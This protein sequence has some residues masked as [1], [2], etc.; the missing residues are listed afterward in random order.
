M[1]LS[2]IQQLWEKQDKKLDK[3]LKLKTDL[4][5]NSYLEKSKKEFNK[6]FLI[7]IIDLPIYILIVIITGSRSFQYLD[8]TLIYLSFILSA[9]IGIAYSTLSIIKIQKFSK[10]NFY[11]NA[12][13]INYQKQLTDL[14]KTILKYKKIE[15]FLMPLLLITL[16]PVASMLVH[17]V[18]IF[19]D[20]TWFIPTYLIC[21]IITYPAALW[22]YKHLYENKLQNIMTFLNEITEYEKSESED[23]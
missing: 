16:L 12:S 10:I 4:L 2:E 5:R 18:N 8:N 17:K 19:D 22:L 21:L 3:Y 15:L 13:I 7:E 1:E 14:R 20:L 11:S 23:I 6:P 9:L